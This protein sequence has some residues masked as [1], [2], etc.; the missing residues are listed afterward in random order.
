[1]PNLINI[2]KSGYTLIELS[3]VIVVIATLLTGGLMASVNLINKNKVSLTNQRIDTIYKALQNY[4]LLNKRLPCP[5]PITD[6]KTSGTGYG[7]DVSTAGVCDVA[8]TYSSTTSTN[9]V[10]GMIPVKDLNLPNEFAEDGY[11]SKFGYIVHKH[12][13]AA[14]S[15]P[16]SDTNSFGTS[17][18]SSLITMKEISG[19]ADKTI[20]TNAIF[21]VI[22][23][24][25]NK[26]GAFNANSSSQN[27]VSSDSYEAYNDITVSTSNSAIFDGTL[28]SSAEVSESF[29]DIVFYKTR[30]AL[31]SDSKAFETIPCKSDATNNNDVTYGATTMTWSATS[32]GKVAAASGPAL[33]VCPAGYTASVAKPTKKCGA[34]GIWEVGAFN[35]CLAAGS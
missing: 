18:D 20:L 4:L 7:D 13:T 23:Y 12:Y 3:I 27:A 9:L 11:G 2:K 19:T 15:D 1:M 21:A 6:S 10:Y 29:D 22:S 32:Y 8:G 17:S 30:N 35:P 31:V 16:Y 14:S 34:F 33:G 28:Y 5:A 26:Y 24:G 25:Y